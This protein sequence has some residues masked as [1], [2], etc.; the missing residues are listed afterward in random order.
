M[1]AQNL[2]RDLNLIKDARFEEDRLTFGPR[3][4][5][6]CTTVGSSSAN[7]LWKHDE[8]KSPSRPDDVPP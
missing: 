1:F 6:A 3:S 8:T 2:K 5:V 4:S 7:R